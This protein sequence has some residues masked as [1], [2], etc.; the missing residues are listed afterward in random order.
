MIQLTATHVPNPEKYLPQYKTEGAACADMVACIPPNIV[1]TVDI[2][3]QI[4]LGFRSIVTINCGFKLAIP[5]G[6][7]FSFAIRSS[8]AQKGIMLM[9]HPQIDSDYRGEVKAVLANFSHSFITIEDGERF[10][11]CWIEPIFK[12]DWSIVENLPSTTRGE[13]GFGSTN[14]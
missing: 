4:K 12:P 8:L 1:D 11:Q 7:K 5:D 14:D 13:G 9:N 6:Y 2:G 10:A 3:T